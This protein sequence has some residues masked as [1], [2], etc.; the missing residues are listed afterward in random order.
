MNNPNF[1]KLSEYP[2][3]KED[4]LTPL[5][6]TLF[7]CIYNLSLQGLKTIT[8]TDIE[9]YLHS[10]NPLGYSKMFE[11]FEGEEWICSLLEDTNIGNFDYYY[12]TVRKYA[13]LRNYLELTDSVNDILN[14]SDM[15]E[16]FNNEQ[17]ERFNKM[18]LN[19]IMEYFDN[20][21]LESKERFFLRSD[22]ES[23]KSGDRAEELRNLLKQSIS[24]GY[25]LEGEYLTTATYGCLGGRVLID[26]RDSGCGEQ[27]LYIFNE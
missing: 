26:T 7:I 16:E 12:N 18:T 25:N 13:L 1:L 15:E 14:F 2:L 4:F 3:D 9:N 19:E 22:T 6:R 23:G 5:H 27:N 24:Y 8:L 20:R 11:K 17:L 21:N 10:T